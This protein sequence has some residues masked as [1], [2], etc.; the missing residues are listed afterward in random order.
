MARSPRTVASATAATTTRAP[1]TTAT[2]ATRPTATAAARAD[3]VTTPRRAARPAV[4]RTPRI[5]ILPYGPSESVNS[6]ANT[7]AE[8]TAEQGTTVLRM[9]REGSRFVGRDA[10]MLINWGSR[11]EAFNTAK[12]TART[13]NSIEAVTNAASKRRA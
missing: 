8:A 13:L 6:L 3:S 5:V 10:D 2:R 9:K 7:L 11:N 12:G 4:P 1:R